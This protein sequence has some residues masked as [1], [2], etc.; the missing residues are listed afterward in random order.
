MN[1]ELIELSEND[2]LTIEG[3]SHFRDFAEGIACGLAGAGFIIAV[4]AL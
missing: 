3:G 1:T 4:M 2:L